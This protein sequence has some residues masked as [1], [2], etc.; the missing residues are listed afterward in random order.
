M[1]VKKSFLNA[2][3]GALILVI[4]SVLLFAVRI[5]FV[6]TLGK[7]LLGVDS[8]F[9]NI[10]VVLSIADAGISTAISFNL[11]KPLSEKNYKKISSL[12][13]FY[14]KAYKRLGIIVLGAGVLFMPFL[15]IIVKENITNLYLFYLIYLFST[16]VTYFI[17]YKDSLLTADQNFYKSSMIVG[18]TYILMYVLRIVFL[19]IWPNFLVF[20]LIQ[21]IMIIIQRV[22]VNRYI[23]KCY[24]MVDF[25]YKEE[26]PK[27]EQKQIF[28]N[29][30]SMFLN[31]IGYFLVNGS[32]NIIISAIPSLGLGTVAIYTNYYSVVGAIDTIIAKAI[33]GVTSSYGDLAV[34]ESKDVQENVF[35]VLSFVNFIIYGLFGVGFFFL[36]T[37][38][39]K[40]C[41]GSSFDIS[42]VTLLVLCL[43]FYL[44]GMIR[45]LDIIKEATGNYYQDRY[46]NIFQAIINI[47]LSIV[48]GKLYGLFGV[49]LATLISFVCLPLWN[50]PYV[51]YK[52]IFNKKP[53]NYLKKQAI[54]FVSL[55]II[56]V[57]CHFTLN[58]VTIDNAVFDF[59]V[60]ALFITIIYLLL[61]SALYCRTK[62]Y[63][64]VVY[65]IKKNRL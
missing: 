15:S 27:K 3:F 43:N 48:L 40:I 63:K 54:Y 47:V 19:L 65:L 49:V 22:L 60:K 46:V 17:S 44:V 29:V 14:K 62:E 57:V 20:A 56:C 28:K 51:A 45:P 26:I 35:N 10:L 52:Y 4:R 50:R 31:K 16:V 5:V 12:M 9:T 41:F 53:Y 30:K 38:L 25:D 34:V 21:P 64:E 23:T 7:T 18:T 58:I 59:V 39:I 11:Y 33:S 13:T 36:L 1:R 42:T 55:L 37:P 61:V 2:F 8:L 32:D 6:K 24:P